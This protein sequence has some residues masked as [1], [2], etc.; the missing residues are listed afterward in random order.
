MRDVTELM[1]HY[2]EVARTLWNT[3]FW[4][5]PKLQTW[6]AW[7]QFEQIKMLLY[8]AFVVARLEG[9]HCCDLT[10]L[11]APVFSVVP[12]A[13]E[14]I[15]IMI[16]KPR[17]GDRNCYWD[18]PVHQVKASEAQFHFID[19]FDW[20]KMARADLQY[21]RVRIV[22]FPTQPHLVGREALIEHLHAKVFATTT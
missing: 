21:Y 11:P 18:D 8:K 17:D 6:N 16:Q 20:N 22:A 2:R 4:V 19:Y 9:G 3:G 13:P 15:P 14:Y 1:D 7:D 12:S 10:T 5:D